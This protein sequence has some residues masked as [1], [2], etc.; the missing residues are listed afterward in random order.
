M[1]SDR[2]E[3]PQML[4]RRSLDSQVAIAFSV[5]V[6]GF[7][8]AKWIEQVIAAGDEE[9]SCQKIHVGSSGHVSVETQM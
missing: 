9:G 8:M 1:I 4:K 7:W 6:A 3:E 5:T 2:A